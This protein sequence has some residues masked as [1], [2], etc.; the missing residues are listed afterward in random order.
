M[1]DKHNQSFTQH[2]NQAGIHDRAPWIFRDDI[3]F[4]VMYLDEIFF[5][6]ETEEN[7]N[8]NN[9]YR[10]GCKIKQDHNDSMAQLN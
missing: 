1:E 5:Y 4:E 10:L 7:R 6:N 8:E 9:I 2:I 3:C